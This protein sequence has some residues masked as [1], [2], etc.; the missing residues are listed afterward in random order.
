MWVARPQLAAFEL[1]TAEEHSKSNLK[2]NK[3]RIDIFK[4]Q[5]VIRFTALLER[6]GGS[7]ERP[8]A[9][10]GLKSR[11]MTVFSN[12]FGLHFE[13]LG[14]LEAFKS[15]LQEVLDAHCLKSRFLKEVFNEITTFGGSLEPQNH[16]ETAHNPC[17]E[18]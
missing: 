2:S 9:A 4:N 6:H 18:P 8:E 16:S 1:K 14:G 13:D 5:R 15:T 17:L 7:F 11:F 12:P 3:K 10:R